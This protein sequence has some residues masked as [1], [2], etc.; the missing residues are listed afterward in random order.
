MRELTLNEIK[1]IELGILLEIHRICKENNYSYSLINGSLL[2]AVRHCGFIPWDDDVDI[3][4]PRSDYEA[5]LDYCETNKT[6]FSLFSTRSK[7]CWHLFSKAFAKNT[8]IRDPNNHDDDVGLGVHVDIFPIDD[9]ANSLLMAKVRFLETSV[10]RE[11]LVAKN[12]KRFYIS[13]TRSKQYEAMRFMAF[14][15]SR[16]IPANYVKLLI[17]NRY[18]RLHSRN[19]KY[20]AMI[21]SAYRM[22]EIVPKQIYEN[23]SDIDFEGNKIQ[24]IEDRD[25]Y[26]TKIY[27]DYMAFPPPEAQVPRHTFKAF[28]IE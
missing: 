7:N 12:W 21:P 23:Y 2:G 5:F 1:S 15:L 16:F 17:E 22:K 8:L 11:L 26:L 4:M 20:V 10:L 3:A 27:G 13:N 24:A 25:Y 9:L 19:L 28:I 6:T 14:I 18:K